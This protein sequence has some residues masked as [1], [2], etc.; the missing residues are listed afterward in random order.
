[1]CR[2]PHP[3]TQD[4]GWP[5]G[6]MGAPSHFPAFSSLC[7]GVTESLPSSFSL[8]WVFALE[9]SSAPV[10]VGLTCCLEHA[11]GFQQLGP[12]I[13]SEHLLAPLGLS[14]C[15]MPR[16]S[17]FSLLCRASTSILSLPLPSVLE[18]RKYLISFVLLLILS[19]RLWFCYSSSVLYH[20][21]KQTN[22]T[23]S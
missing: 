22:L 9:G 21:Q 6:L 18:L 12:G 10:A 16:A 14:V 3:A 20:Q 19:M 15:H 2:G 17:F 13:A 8:M 23:V 4:S 11:S 5:C 1:M 7:A